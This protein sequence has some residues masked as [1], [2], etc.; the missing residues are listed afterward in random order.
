MFTVE[1]HKDEMN[2]ALRKA[3]AGGRISE[4]ECFLALA[5]DHAAILTALTLL[6]LTHNPSCIPPE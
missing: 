3:A 6:S 2:A 5:A 4:T 1:Y